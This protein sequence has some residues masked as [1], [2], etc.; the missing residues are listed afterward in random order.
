MRDYAFDRVEIGIGS[1]VG[2]SQHIFGVEDVE[3]LVLHRPHI[4]IADRYDVVEIEIIFAAESFLIPFHRLLQ[5]FNRMVSAR[6][7]LFT[8][9]DIQFDFAAGH[10]GERARIRD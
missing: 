2:V 3:P 9:P 5:A 7:V 6:Q 4:E 10:G 8:H 1:G